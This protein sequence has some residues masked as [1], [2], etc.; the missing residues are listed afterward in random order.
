M[1]DHNSWGR[2][3]DLENAKEVVAKFERRMNT[4]K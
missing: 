1:A 3:E 2:K 4:E